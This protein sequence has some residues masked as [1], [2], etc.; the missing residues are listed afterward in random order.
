MT[1]GA[2]TTLP[3]CPLRSS[4]PR[5]AGWVGESDKWTWAPSTLPLSGQGAALCLTHPPVMSVCLC[6]CLSLHLF[7]FRHRPS[8]TSLKL[9]CAGS[10]EGEEGSKYLC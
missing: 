3:P 10:L 6:V 5:Q 1:P 9:L 7:I 8:P 4:S 2:G